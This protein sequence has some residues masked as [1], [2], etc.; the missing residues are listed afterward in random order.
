M[1][2]PHREGNSTQSTIT[3]M[4]GPSQPQEAAGPSRAQP[5]DPGASS[6][7]DNGEDHPEYEDPLA[8]MSEIDKWG[9]KGFSYLMRNYP[10]YAAL[11]T[12]IDLSTLGFDLNSPEYVML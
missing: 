6:N 8:H 1:A 12:G 2:P 5:V 7:Q 9:L 11:V 10:D 3:R 4:D